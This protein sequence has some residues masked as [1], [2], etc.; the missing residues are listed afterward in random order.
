M[1]K[2]LF[3]LLMLPIFL[4]GQSSYHGGMYPSDRQ[5]ACA[6]G[7][8][9]SGISYPLFWSMYGGSN[10]KNSHLLATISS[11]GV[12]IVASMFTYTYGPTKNPINARQNVTASLCSSAVTITLIRIGLN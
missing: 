9:A 8:C 7:I 3:L 6:T 4:F 11:V 2:L 5:N 10:N 12:S 1:K